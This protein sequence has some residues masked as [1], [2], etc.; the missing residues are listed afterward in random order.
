[1]KVRVITA[2]C[3]I[4]VVVPLAI[5]GSWWSLALMLLFIGG[6]IV[7]LLEVRHDNSWPWYFK[8]IVYLFS[9]TMLGW[10]FITNWIQ[11]GVFTLPNPYNIG[12]NVY[13]LGLYLLIL[14]CFEITTPR[15]KAVDVFYLFAM[16]LML[17]LAGQAF[18]AVRINLGVAPL[19]YVL[20]ITY[21][22]DTFALLI[23]SKFGKHKLAPVI[24]PKKTWEGAIGGIVV[25]TICGI[26]FY[27]IFPF[28]GTLLNLGWII[29]FSL[30]LSIGGVFGDLVFSSIKRYF[31]MKDFGNIFPGHGGVLDRI[32]S[33][34][35][36]L[37][38]F[39]VLYLIATG[40]LIV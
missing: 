16:T 9:L 14:F 11:T 17:T 7:E 18:M 15:I 26:A 19:F 28:G 22:N 38:L 29:L 33:I 10:P 2:L 21:I 35:F 23:G 24:S 5:L 39:I 4:A 31:E 12:M 32:D 27:L 6:G 3:I 36:N 37:I 13:F 34:V 25:A 20:F 40:G 8:I 1:M 30:I